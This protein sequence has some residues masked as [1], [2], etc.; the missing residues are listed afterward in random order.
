MN[1]SL[2][3]PFDKLSIFPGIAVFAG[4]D[5]QFMTL[6]RIGTWR[7]TPYSINTIYNCSY[8]QF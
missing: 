4:G 5:H 7:Y 1:V 8:N 6:E 3:L 2:L